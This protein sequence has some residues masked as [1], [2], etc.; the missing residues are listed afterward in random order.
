MYQNLAIK[1]NTEPIWDI[2]IDFSL[3]R[4][5]FQPKEEGRFYNVLGYK[6]DLFMFV[7]ICIRFL[8]PSNRFVYLCAHMGWLHYILTLRCSSCSS[9]FQI[10]LIIVDLRIQVEV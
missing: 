6:N 1:K 9:S 7:Y 10:K 4:Q 3:R 5:P 8:F 2:E